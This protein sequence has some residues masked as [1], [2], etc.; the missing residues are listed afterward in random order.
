M[1][2][3]D[4]DVHAR[5]R[6]R[7]NCARALAVLYIRSAGLTV[8]RADA[9]DK[10][11]AVIRSRAR[12]SAMIVTVIFMAAIKDDW[13]VRKK[14][15]SYGRCSR[16]GARVPPPREEKLLNFNMRG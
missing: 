9:R 13:K 7:S 12:A 8:F 4:D 10:L 2:S 11:V 3:R 6:A 14:G 16:L 15:G 5:A 1:Q